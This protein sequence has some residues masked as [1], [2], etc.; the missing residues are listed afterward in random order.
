MRCVLKAQQAAQFSACQ[1]CLKSKV[2]HLP[3][4]SITGLLTSPSG[5]IQGLVIAEEDFCVLFLI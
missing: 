5:L 4:C 2:L 1:H 3:V